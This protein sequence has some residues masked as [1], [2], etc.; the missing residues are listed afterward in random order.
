MVS[1]LEAERELRKCSKKADTKSE[2]WGHIVVERKRRKQND[3]KTVMQDAMELKK[4]RIWN[5]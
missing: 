5:L 1:V 3:G 4:R 2:R